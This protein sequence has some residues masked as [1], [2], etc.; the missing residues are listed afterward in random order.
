MTH[1]QTRFPLATLV[2]EASKRL[3]RQEIRLLSLA[4]REAA[5]R[6]VDHGIPGL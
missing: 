6:A 4:A 5:R 1:E 3:A 2:I